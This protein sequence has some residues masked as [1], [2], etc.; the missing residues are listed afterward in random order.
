MMDNWT[1]I[2]FH[3]CWNCVCA[4]TDSPAAA[5]TTNDDDMVEFIKSLGLKRAIGLLDL[6]IAGAPPLNIVALGWDQ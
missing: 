4:A 6:T 5:I 1:Y 3:S 2:A